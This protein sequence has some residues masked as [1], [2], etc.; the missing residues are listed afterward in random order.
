MLGTKAEKEVT[1][2]IKC[3]QPNVI[4]LNGQTSLFEIIALG[5]KAAA[6]IGNDTGPMH[7]I[8]PTGCPT[9]VLFSAHSNAQKHYPLGAHIKIINSENLAELS[10]EDVISSITFDKEALQQNASTIH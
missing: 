1:D 9:T 2:Q 7:M 5:A 3:L 8:A 4:D 6:C 10:V